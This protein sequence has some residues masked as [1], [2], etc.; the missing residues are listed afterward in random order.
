VVAQLQHVVVRYYVQLQHLNVDILLLRVVE[1]GVLQV[2]PAL[3]LPALIEIV[4]VA[5]ALRVAQRLLRLHVICAFLEKDVAVH[6]I[7]KSYRYVAL[8]GVH[9]VI[10]LLVLR[11]INVALLAQ[12]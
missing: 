3:L 5:L 1:V 4:F 7:R 8:T 2:K 12:H 9:G 6:L 11:D 10:Q